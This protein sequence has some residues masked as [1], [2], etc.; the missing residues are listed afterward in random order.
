MKRNALKYTASVMCAD[1]L[2]LERD[3]GALERSGFDELHYDI[4]DGAFVPNLT[5]GFDVIRLAKARCGLAA[6]AHLMLAKPEKYIERFVEAGC[7]SITIHVE[8]CTHAP[9][10]LA[11]IRDL[12]ASPGIAIN[13]ATPL[14]KLD[15]L[16]EY[17][18]R[19]L[20]M[21]VDPGYAGQ[22]L[23]SSSFERVRIL[24][25]NVSYRERNIDIEVDGNISATNAAILANQGANRFVLGTA[26]VF[27][28]RFPQLDEA[29][30]V[31][32]DLV[33]AERAVV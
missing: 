3:L 17:V 28:K 20:V 19:V 15:Y 30:P 32:R 21:T 7:D 13:P 22:T 18:D 6:S 14:T 26:S 2:N 1:L 16:F 23:I 9:R 24:R 10:I 31:F 4:M 27:N 29:L 5:L 25:D 33:D 11:A 12:G 8:A